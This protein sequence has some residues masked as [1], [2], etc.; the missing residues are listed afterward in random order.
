MACKGG[1]LAWGWA[2]TAVDAIFITNS[3]KCSEMI[4]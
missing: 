1:T 4:L 3:E 2:W